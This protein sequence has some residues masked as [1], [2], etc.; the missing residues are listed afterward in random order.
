MT[1]AFNPHVIVEIGQA[2]TLPLSL[3]SL[4]SDGSR[5]L[6]LYASSRLTTS[7][8]DNVTEIV[9][10]GLAPETVAAL[11]EHGALCR[12]YA[13]WR[14]RDGR[15]TPSQIAAGR[16]LPATVQGPTRE[17]ADYLTRWSIN[18]GGL[19]LRDVL[20]SESWSGSVTAEE[21][22]ERLLAVSGLA[23]GEIRLGRSAS[24]SQGYTVTSTLRRALAA[25]ARVT[26]SEI[27]VQDGAIQAWPA[28]GT[29]RT[30][31]PILTPN[32]GLLDDPEPQ[33]GG[34][35]RVRS[36]LLP[37]VRPG[38]GVRVESRQLTGSA[39]VLDVLHTV[40][41]EGESCDTLLTVRP[42]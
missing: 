39:V 40:D 12:V 33:D 2:G 1:Q 21:V 42:T 29:R 7:K 17:G 5:G 26:Q 14:G 41:T 16:V 25:I 22:L 15:G 4:R 30:S 19:D 8:Q 23:R 37:A 32:T 3:S 6:R 34:T 11:R 38:D 18:D 36:L 28:G 9:A 24:W 27:V 20:V 31:G 10:W 35:W 13:G